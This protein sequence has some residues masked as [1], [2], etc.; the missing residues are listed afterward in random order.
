M[1]ITG[2]LVR[3]HNSLHNRLFRLTFI[4]TFF[5]LVLIFGAYFLFFVNYFRSNIKSSLIEKN[6]AITTI[7]YESVES[8][9][10][11][12]LKTLVDSNLQRFES[13]FSLKDNVEERKQKFVQCLMKQKIGKTGYFYVLS[14][15]GVVLYHNRSELVGEGL[16]EYDFVKEMLQDKK[17]FIEYTW[18]N[19]GET[20]EREKVLYM[21]YIEEWDWIV[22]ASVYKTEF[23]YFFDPEDFKGALD[24]FSH[25]DMGYSFIID[26]SGTFILHPDYQGENIYK[27]RFLK[28]YNIFQRIKDNPGGFIFYNWKYEGSSTQVEKLMAFTFIQGLGWYVGSTLNVKEASWLLRF[29][30]WGTVAVFTLVFVGL[31][32]FFFF[33]ERNIIAPLKKLIDIIKKNTIDE[34]D[35]EISEKWSGELQELYQQFLLFL[36]MIKKKN[37][38]LDLLADFTDFNP[39]P[40]LR[41]NKEM[42][43]SY[44]NEAALAYAENL[45]LGLGEALAED[46]RGVVKTAMTGGTTEEYTNGLW[47]FLVS[48]SQVKSG[49]EIYV[50]LLDATNQKNI[51]HLAMIS[52]TVFNNTLEGICITDSEGCIEQVNG[53]FE[54]ITGYSR[55]EVIGENPRILK[56]EKHEAGFYT[57][58]W[59][60]LKNH[61][62]WSGEIWNRKKGGDIYAE[63]LI[64]QALTDE[65]GETQKYLA[66]FHDI[67]EIKN[68]E[69]EIDLYQN[70]DLLTALPNKH[71]F[72]D[73]LKVA[74]SAI[75]EHQN[76]FALL[77]MDIAHFKRINEGFGHNVGDETLKMVAEYLKANTSIHN[78]VARME[79]NRFAL[80]F[81]GPNPGEFAS[82][83][84]HKIEMERRLD[85]RIQDMVISL[86]FN[87]G[88]SVFSVDAGDALSLYQAAEVALNNA[89]ASTSTS[90]SF[91]NASFHEDARRTIYLESRLRQAIDKRELYFVFQPQVDIRMKELLGFEALVRW[92]VD[93]KPVSPDLF[94]GMAEERNMARDVTLFALEESARLIADIEKRFG[95]KIKGSINVSADQF[96]DEN[97][98]RLLEQTVKQYGFEPG[99]INIEITERSTVANHEATTKRLD[100]LQSF[101]CTISVDDFG[102]GYSSLNYLAQFPLDYLKID[103]SFVWALYSSSEANNLVRAIINI[104]HTIGAR[105]IAEGV[106]EENQRYFLEKFDCDFLQGYLYAKP[107]EY[108]DFIEV[109]RQNFLS[110]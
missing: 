59:S 37:H 20:R 52:E 65:S 49:E 32:V 78:N 55:K 51:A 28:E 57:A 38:D 43:L 102:T 46:L 91:Y 13:E 48:S 77:L 12:S 94:M 71:L 97:L 35:L 14:G 73:R 89:K 42:E 66:I 7:L 96:Q 109:A 105:V 62:V 84:A 99:L 29:L 27:N 70:Y 41:V 79:G 6:R 106:E 72:F 26:N 36:K 11:S 18:K 21:D 22:S 45:K 4:F 75:G 92:D 44:L 87:F 63:Y 40:V 31:G 53:S 101:G 24:S 93:G 8:S 61:G 80:T 39:N 68:K 1:G 74:C 30:R 33:L 23:S 95:K 108:E 110:I 2:P 58:M 81:Y 103:K 56:S 3:I 98:L 86:E 104:G 60:E 69:K 82:A 67:T 15:D 64:I 25:G 9:V 90:I 19:P 76:S 5:V 107:L 54:I 100:D 47:T 88:I 50:Y 83:F 10:K 17:G 16:S 85:L 34:C